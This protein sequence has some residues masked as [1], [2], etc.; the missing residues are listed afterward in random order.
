MKIFAPILIAVVTLLSSC[1][2]YRYELMST[3]SNKFIDGVCISHFDK[4]E[5]T[6]K[7][8][9]TIKPGGITS[10]RQRELTNFTFQANFQSSGATSLKV[11]LRTVRHEFDEN[12]GIRIEISDFDIKIFEN[13]KLRAE[14]KHNLTDNYFRNKHA[15]NY[16]KIISEGKSIIIETDC[17]PKTHIHSE[18][19]LSEY[20]ILQNDS[21]GDLNFIGIV[22]EKNNN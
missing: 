14:E 20:V 12:I 4:I 5:K 10:L 2:P 15:L 9:I 11:Y 21:E 22:I 1:N 6:D 18:L 7:N 8:S 3:D 19:T 16:L 17:H 13:D